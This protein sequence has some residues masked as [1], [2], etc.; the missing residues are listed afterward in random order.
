MGRAVE[1]DVKGPSPFSPQEET[2]PGPPALASASG[3]QAAHGAGNAE[4]GSKLEP[5]STHTHESPAQ[6]GGVVTSTP[7]RLHRHGEQQQRTAWGAH[8]SQGADGSLDGAA[9]ASQAASQAEPP[10]TARLA[11][12]TPAERGLEADMSPQP[13]ASAREAGPGRSKARSRLYTPQKSR[14]SPIGGSKVG[15]WSTGPESGGRTRSRLLAAAERQPAGGAMADPQSH[16]PGVPHPGLDGPATARIKARQSSAAAARA[17]Y[18]GGQGGRPPSSR[19]Q[20]DRSRVRHWSR[21]GPRHRPTTTSGDGRRRGPGPV[22][23]SSR[24]RGASG[25]GRVSTAAGGSRAQSA[26][27]P[28]V[29]AE[30][31]APVAGEAIPSSAAAVTDVGWGQRKARE[32]AGTGFGGGRGGTRG[33]SRSRSTRHARQQPVS[34]AAPAGRADG[35][36]AY[37]SPD[38]A[39][40][41]HQAI[42]SVAK[43][44]QASGSGGAAV[45]RGKTPRGAGARHFYPGAGGGSAY[46]QASGGLVRGTDGHWRLPPMPYGRDA[47]MLAGGGLQQGMGSRRGGRMG[48][49]GQGVSAP[50]STGEAARGLAAAERNGVRGRSAAGD[51]ASAL[52]AGASA[53]GPGP[54]HG[55]PRQ[56]GPGQGLSPR[57]RQRLFGQPK[58]GAGL[59]AGG[60]N[61]GLPGRPQPPAGRSRVGG[62]SPRHPAPPGAGRR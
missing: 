34:A 55:K 39:A 14:T 35:S 40:S 45:A 49:A 57:M 10:A 32:E 1:D 43:A 16:V 12:P 46:R 56:R 13:P 47:M 2:L 50:V 3:A 44:R 61:G 11:D 52:A 42:M 62:S 58:A 8:P 27:R 51:R 18:G 22:G 33:H 24:V 36:H 17:V 37:V 20:R 41:A 5:D 60:G 9:T 48:V 23:A 7:A 6:D 15:P 54:A 53:A 28:R 21:Q 59:A 29:N 30:A 4:S 31:A 38:D 25:D 26:Q 19:H